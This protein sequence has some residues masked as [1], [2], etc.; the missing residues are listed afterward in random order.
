MRLVDRDADRVAETARE[1]DGDVTT[2]VVDV[3]SDDGP[4]TI[5]PVSD[6]PSSFSIGC[7]S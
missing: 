6:T 5:E 7:R 4:R 1:I 2:L 3:A